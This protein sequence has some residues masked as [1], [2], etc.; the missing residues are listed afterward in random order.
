ML[1]N[2]PMRFLLLL[3]AWLSIGSCGASK[4]A[5]QQT[6]STPYLQLNFKVPAKHNAVALELHSLE[7]GPVLLS[8][9]LDNLSGKVELQDSLSQVMDSPMVAFV[10]MDDGSLW[11]ARLENPELIS[12]NVRSFHFDLVELPLDVPQSKLRA[13][14]LRQQNLSIASGEYSGITL[15]KDDVY[16]TVHDKSSGG[17]IHFFKIPISASGIVGEVGEKE[18]PGNAGLP[19]GRDNEDIVYVSSSETL[20]VSSEGDQQIREYSLEGQPTGR[21]LQVPEDLKAIQPNAGFE[22]LAYDAANGYFWAATEKS[23]KEEGLHER[24]IRLQRFNGKTLEADARYLY[25][26]GNPVVSA[27]QAASAQAYVFGLSAMTVLP[28]GRLITLEREVYVP[29]GSIIEKALGAFTLST[30]YVIDP[31]KD[32][33]G[34]LQKQQLCRVVTSALNLANYEGMCLG[35]KL[36]GGRQTILL[37]ADS[38]NGSGGLTGEYLHLIAIR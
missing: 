31:L 12:G 17:G 16:A 25:L 8:R 7:T 10:Q 27:E 19:G 3:L 34:I 18:A 35:P 37:L 26:M 38:Q 21:S 9:N 15:V 29:G 4:R 6:D 23:L 2:I 14:S 28:D 30:L 24:M 32:K 33:A 13:E 5:Q 11:T 36:S 22:A 1:P 20:F